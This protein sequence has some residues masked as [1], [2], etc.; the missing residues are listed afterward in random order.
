M[1][2]IIDKIMGPLYHSAPSIGKY[3][4][5]G[6]TGQQTYTVPLTSF[7]VDNFIVFANNNFLDFNHT[8]SG[9]DI[10]IIGYN[11][12]DGDNLTFVGIG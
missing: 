11:V 5:T 4:I 7:K 8:H 12:Q 1:P 2:L 9:Q 3:T 10:T 6:V